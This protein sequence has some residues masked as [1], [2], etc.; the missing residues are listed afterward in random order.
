MS[1]T[2]S[3]VYNLYI[4]IHSALNRTLNAACVH[5]HRKM[6]TLHLI[7]TIT[8]AYVGSG[9]SE[10]SFSERTTIYPILHAIRKKNDFTV[11]V[12]VLV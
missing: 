9:T 7:Q 5:S 3:T 11:V 1:L 12:G 10:T 8:Y 4:Y 2:H 6:D